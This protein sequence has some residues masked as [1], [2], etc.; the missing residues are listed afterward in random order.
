[1]NVW[2]FD[3]LKEA[4]PIKRLGIHGLWRL[5]HYG[6]GRF[7]DYYPEIRKS[8]TL[9]WTLTDTSVTLRFESAADL[10][11][12]LSC[13]L[14]DFRYGVGVLP[15][16]QPEPGRTGFYATARAHQ[17]TC[18][19]K[20]GNFPGHFSVKKGTR[21]SESLLPPK[22]VAEDTEETEK[23]RE[24][25]EAK[26]AFYL[27]WKAQ[28]GR[29]P[30]QAVDHLPKSSSTEEKPTSLEIK[31]SPHARSKNTIAI[32]EGKRGFKSDTFS[33]THH[34]AY[35]QWNLHAVKGEADELFIVAFSCLSY[36]HTLA[37][38]GLLALGIDLP[39][40]AEAD[41]KHRLW[42]ADQDP[43]NVL[44]VD[45]GT[46]TATWLIAAV[47][48][49]PART[50]SVLSPD[51]PFLFFP[52]APGRD[53]S[54]VYRALSGALSPRDKAGEIKGTQGVPTQ[55]RIKRKKETEEEEKLAYAIDAIV[56]NLEHGFAWYRDL[57]GVATVLRLNNMTGLYPAEREALRR[58][59]ERP[60]SS[61]ESPMEQQIATRMKSLFESLVKAYHAHFSLPQTQDGW[62]RARDKAR[63]FAIRVHLNRAFNRETIFSS[64]SRIHA[65][66]GNFVPFFNADEFA[67]L[68][69]RTEEN[70][71]EVR[72]L[73][74]FACEVRSPAKKKDAAPDTAATT[75]GDTAADDEAA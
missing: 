49:L 21:R 41:E 61:L 43:R 20:D 64:L 19:L 45:G 66:S 31:I 10:N 23:E 58:I 4:N 63:D 16:Y 47:L 42:G 8:A 37:S 56:H 75:D 32:E 24:K 14:G 74:I 65:E 54:Q 2:T 52:D 69:K 27:D 62:E 46:R 55:T 29:E 17:G 33:S 59:T 57:A 60:Y 18:Y 40:F 26:A 11:R 9:D 6:S 39:T 25:R 51:G 70:P 22:P 5:L 68:L 35:S 38:G 34:P 3:L 28:F 30:V 7:A 15:G 53:I 36:V 13:Q 48:D 67:W 71:G 44:W 50:Y 1:M 73:L 72:S 12:L